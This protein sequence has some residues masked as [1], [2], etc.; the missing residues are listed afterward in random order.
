MSIPP[1]QGLSQAVAARALRRA[2]LKVGNVVSRPSNQF[3]AGQ[4]TGTNPG[5]ARGVPRGFTVT[6]F[7]SS[8]SP[9][10]QVPNVV[11]ETQTQATSDLTRAG[12]NVQQRNQP[13]GSATPGNVISQTPPGNT[14]AAN[15]STVIITVATAPATTTVPTVTGDPVDGAISALTAAGFKVSQTSRT[16]TNPDQNGTVVAQ[17]PGGNSTAKKGSTVTIAVG[18]LQTS[19]SSSTTTT[20]TTRT[21]TT[22]PT[23]PTTSTTS[24]HAQ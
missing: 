8:G 21:T 9:Q 16:V 10:K 17:S 23:T 20:S 15:G 1:V 11:G 3:P 4:A 22:T 2:G 6:L 12:F 14:K 7:V 5:V 18:K 24:S 13:S 19:S